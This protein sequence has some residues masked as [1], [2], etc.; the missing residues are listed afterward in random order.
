MATD[1][2]R[3]FQN[4]ADV[5]SS[6][7]E[8]LQKQNLSVEQKIKILRRWEYDERELSVAE[9]ENMAGGPPSKLDDI[10]S[11]LRQLAVKN[12]SEHAPPTKQG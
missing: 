4:P 10:L 9:E 8:I 12:H 5:F 1:I 11:A 7:Q 2:N 3:V 6:P